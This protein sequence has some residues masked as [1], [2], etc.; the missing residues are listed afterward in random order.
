VLVVPSRD[1]VER[2]DIVEPRKGVLKLTK[3]IL[4]IEKT[5]DIKY[6]KSSEKLE[7]PTRGAVHK[8]R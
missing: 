3:L 1:R 7:V 4:Q 6:S 5:A 2:R 8:L